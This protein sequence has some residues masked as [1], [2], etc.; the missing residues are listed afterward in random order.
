MSDFENFRSNT[1]CDMYDGSYYASRTNVRPDGAA[2][3]PEHVLR[4][5]QNTENKNFSTLIL[6][7]LTD[8]F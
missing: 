6:G 8:I 3:C 2:A 7:I 5:S 4:F 1:K